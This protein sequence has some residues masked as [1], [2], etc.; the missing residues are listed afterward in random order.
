VD[1]GDA[2]ATLF[3]NHMSK[4]RHGVLSLSET[5][6]WYF[7]PGKSKEGILLPDLVADFQ[8]LMDTAQFFKGHT[9]FNNVYNARMQVSLQNC[10]LHHVSAHGLKSLVA[11]TSRKSHDKLSPDNKAICDEAYNDGYDG[12]VSFKGCDRFLFWYRSSLPVQQPPPG[13]GDR[14]K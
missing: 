12:L 10:V 9:K 7:Y 6:D 1:Q 14:L 3:F 8:N 13:P 5:N 4:P 11:P 2:S